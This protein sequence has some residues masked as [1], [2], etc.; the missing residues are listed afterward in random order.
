MPVSENSLNEFYKGLK[1]LIDFETGQSKGA[2][3]IESMAINEII[4]YFDEALEKGDVIA[5]FFLHYLANKYPAYIDQSLLPD[6]SSVPAH[7]SN[8]DSWIENYCTFLLVY[9]KINELAEPGAIKVTGAS[10]AKNYQ[11]RLDAATNFVLKKINGLKETDTPLSGVLAAKALLHLNDKTGTQAVAAQMIVECFERSA[12]FPNVYGMYE[13]KRYLEQTKRSAPTE[14]MERKL[15]TELSLLVDS[16]GDV[17]QLMNH[18]RR[19]GEKGLQFFSQWFYVALC[20]GELGNVKTMI[21]NYTNADPSQWL[22]KISPEG[23]LEEAIKW[24]NWYKK[25]LPLTHARPEHCRMVINFACNYR[26]FIGNNKYRASFLCYALDSVVQDGVP[27]PELSVDRFRDILELTWKL[28]GNKLPSGVSLISMNE[29]AIILTRRHQYRAAEDIHRQVYSQDKVNPNYQY[30]LAHILDLQAKNI[31]EQIQLYFDAAKQ[32]CVDSAQVLFRI[33]FIEEKGTVEDLIQFRDWVDLD[34][35]TLEFMMAKETLIPLITATIFQRHNDIKILKW[36]RIE[37]D[38][39]AY[40]S[41]SFFFNDEESKDEEITDPT[42]DKRA[43]VL[44]QAAEEPRQG[45][46][47]P[48]TV[49]V[50]KHAPENAH[51]ADPRRRRALDTLKGIHDKP[52]KKLN[53]DDLVQAKR[54]FEIL[55]GGE[56]TNVGIRHKRGSRV[57]VGNEKLHLP[58]GGDRMV[59][60][61]QEQIKHSVQRLWDVAS[62]DSSQQGASAS[63]RPSW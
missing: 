35:L 37:Q 20:H 27:M 6:L 22:V 3:Q 8:A 10:Q 39:T 2:M 32:R 19:L 25:H 43:A 16:R 60:G 57:K 51:E 62:A 55:F 7:K 63:E 9:N 24:F 58:H 5:P 21:E 14:E 34:I 13:Y 29:M 17:S 33:L 42:R 23:M 30:N 1:R 38:G 31:P 28:N 54:A 18:Y 44:S 56:P 41:V 15:Q 50:F 48:S 47:F 49:T 36:N 11:T 52:T 40:F 61:A 59:R 46:A 53:I 12:Y 4:S 45:I 26:N